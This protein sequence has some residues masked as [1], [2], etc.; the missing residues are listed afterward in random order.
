MTACSRLPRALPFFLL[1]LL[2]LGFALFPTPRAFAHDPFE[3]TADGRLSPDKLV[4]HITM[5]RSTAYALI[6]PGILGGTSFTPEVLPRVI[7]AF[8]ARAG[9][10]LEVEAGDAPLELRKT[11]VTITQEEDVDFILEYTPPAQ[12]PL[13]FRATHV[14]KLGYGYGVTLTLTGDK[15]FLGSKLLME[16]DL[17]LEVP[18]KLPSDGAPSGA[19]PSEPD[20]APA[21]PS[22]SFRSYLLLGIEHILGGFDHLLFLAALLVVC[23]SLRRF[24]II[25]TCFT[26][27]HSLTLGLAALDLVS[28]SPAIVEP[29]IAAS[30]V[31]VAAEN[32]LR[33]GQEPAGRGW[34]TLTFGLIHGF[35]FA[36]ALKATGLGRDMMSVAAPLFSFNL[37]VELG[38]LL[39]AAVG[40]PLWWQ[41]RKF[42][43][44]DRFGAMIVSAA[45]GAA[46]VYWLLERTVL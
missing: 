17:V 33:R 44:I 37:G 19:G 29:L 18:I 11:V 30:I 45:V 13:R 46:G 31:Y 1:A 39:V 38:Q 6:E 26:L 5:S 23:R 8:E 21:R 9:D 35:G 14:Q 40:L 42:K 20:P 22:F 36:G 32:L 41:L 12:S 7:A 4:L 27:A 28:L 34:L 24:F 43:P 10:I 15:E 3:I 2:A 25:I 16:H